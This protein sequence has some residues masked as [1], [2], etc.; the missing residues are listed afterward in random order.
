MT[1]L[2]N[3][4]NITLCR[5]ELSLLKQ[6][7]IIRA[8]NDHFKNGDLI[9][10][11]DTV[12]YEIFFGKAALISYKFAMTNSKKGF[13]YTTTALCHMKLS[14]ASSSSSSSDESTSVPDGSSSVQS[15]K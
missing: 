6:F 14:F 10:R 2:S 15:E 12:S 7:H 1:N 9:I 8:F 3:V 5:M 4:L 13:D 11:D